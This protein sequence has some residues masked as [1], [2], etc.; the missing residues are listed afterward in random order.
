MNIIPFILTLVPRPG[1]K[2][3][4]EYL[5]RGRIFTELSWDHYGGESIVFKHPTMSS[6]EMHELN[7]Q[8]LQEGYSMGRVLAKTFHKVKKRTSLS[9]AMNSFFTQTS[10]KKSFREQFKKENSQKESWP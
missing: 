5:D 10:L 8:V 2:I 6:E 4:N 9:V 1:S 7:A 3:Y